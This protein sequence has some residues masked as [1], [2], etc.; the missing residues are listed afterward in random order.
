MKSE[1]CQN[2]G[3]SEVIHTDRETYDSI[4]PC[5][6][7]EPVSVKALN[8]SKKGCGKNIMRM[9]GHISNIYIC[10]N[11]D[12]CP[13]CKPKNHSPEDLGRY[14]RQRMRVSRSPASGNHSQQTGTYTPEMEKERSTSAGTFNLSENKKHIAG[15]VYYR[16]VRVKE[17]IKILKE[18]IF[19]QITEWELYE[20]R[21]PHIGTKWNRIN[22]RIQNI[23]DKNLGDDLIK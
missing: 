13:K 1:I 7:F 2:C 5:K 23:I 4:K 22:T 8:A 16:A 15:G 9:I 10:Q 18:D 14:N 17:F 20:K 11:E 19:H 3:Y 12:L 6:K 21:F